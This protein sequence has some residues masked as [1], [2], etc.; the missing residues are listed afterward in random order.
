MNTRQ[1][2]IKRQVKQAPA[3][4]SASAAP[5]RLP[6][7]LLGLALILAVLVHAT[8]LKFGFVDD[9][10]PQILM[11][12]SVQAW[13]FLPHYFV[14]DVWSHWGGCGSNYYR[15]VFLVWLLLNYRLFGPHAL[16]WHAAV[17]LLHAVV[18]GLVFVL[19]RRELKDPVA[20]GV[21]ALI[22]AVHPVTVESVV[23]ISGATE[24]LL[25]LLFLGSL[26]C[27]LRGREARSAAWKTLALVLFALA[28]LAKETA[29][30]LPLLVLVYEW[31]SRPEAPRGKR[32]RAAAAA[33]APYAAV[34]VAYLAARA[35]ALQGMAPAFYN[36][37]SA[38][39]VISTWPAVVCFYLKKLVYPWPLG[40]CYGLHLIE[41]R[42]LGS[43]LLPSAVMV[44]AGVGLWAWCRRESRAAVPCA[45]LFL[46]LLPVI[47]GT[48]RFQRDQ[49][50]HDRYLY[51]PLMGFAML[52]A[53]GARRLRLGKRERREVP[54]AQLLVLLAVTGAFGLTS[55]SYSRYWSS[56]LALYTRAVV[57]AP[58]SADA[59]AFLGQELFNRGTSPGVED[60]ATWTQAA[61]QYFRRAIAD[62]PLNP[63]AYSSLG[64]V[65][66]V[67]KQ[68]DAAE[69][70]LSQAAELAG[71]ACT[72]STL[73]GAQH[74]AGNLAG[75]EASYRRALDRAPV[76]PHLHGQFAALLMEEGKLAEAREQLKAELAL[77]PESQRA[78]RLL[79]QLER[80]PGTAAP[81]E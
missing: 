11:N 22:F 2:Q 23:F 4:A 54:L 41:H 35:F 29:A 52:C 65:Y 64:T 75:A 34:G 53:L 27:Y 61:L 14:S 42:A 55:F 48:L 8:A 24:A 57:V 77:D 78:R 60:G 69:D 28:L 7:M 72:Y 9:D 3:P 51:V 10:K 16:G 30:V 56:N 71:D 17:L 32:I 6:W 36:H 68:W 31:R 46:P 39:T 18:T 1:K 76:P 38:W 45:W 19:A 40:P 70:Y 15:P 43:L 58:D 73:A 37:A 63:E 12:P 62:D 74:S 25:G 50:V 66:S 5:S 26:L 67:F 79:E 47:V 59:N 49:L 20:A 21:A 33:L 81:R 13:H 80:Q 44:A